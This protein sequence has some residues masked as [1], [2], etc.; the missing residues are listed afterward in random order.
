MVF[1]PSRFMGD[2]DQMLFLQ[3]ERSASKVHTGDE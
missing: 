2:G 3:F 1:L